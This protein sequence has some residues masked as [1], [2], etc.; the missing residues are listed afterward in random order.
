MDVLGHR[1]KQGG[2]HGARCEIDQQCLR[3]ASSGGGCNLAAADTSLYQG[4]C[5]ADTHLKH[6]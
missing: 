4:R 5:A 6:F 1:K 3:L 2:W